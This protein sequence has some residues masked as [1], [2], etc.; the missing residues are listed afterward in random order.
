MR[1]SCERVC[2]RVCVYA[3]TGATLCAD[4]G[5]PRISIVD[6]TR[7]GIGCRFCGRDYFTLTQWTI[8]NRQ[9]LEF[10]RFNIWRHYHTHSHTHTP[11]SVTHPTTNK[12]HCTNNTQHIVQQLPS[13][14]RSVYPL[15]HNVSYIQASR[16]R[17][18]IKRIDTHSH[19]HVEHISPHCMVFCS[20][21]LSV[22]FVQ[23]VRRGPRTLGALI[24]FPVCGYD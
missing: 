16:V 10:G 23:P 3:D 13:T 7:H 5:G 17:A 15:E 9:S 6:V 12:N 2:V 20:C 22:K 21:I 24:I 8:N 19:T 18:H 14:G 1:I 11:N 4:A